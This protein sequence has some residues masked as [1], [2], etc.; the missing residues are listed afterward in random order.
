MSHQHSKIVIGREYLLFPKRK[1][2]LRSFPHGGQDEWY[3]IL[4]LAISVSRY[5]DLICNLI[6]ADWITIVLLL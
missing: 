1:V 5:M 6:S 4:I 2:S 3:L